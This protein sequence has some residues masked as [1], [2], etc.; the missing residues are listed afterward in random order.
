MKK[1]VLPFLLITLAA[2]LSFATTHTITNSGFTFTPT[3]LTINVGD[4]VNFVLDSIHQPR[5]VS[6]AT[7]NANG[8]TSNGGFNL[9]LGGGTVVIT[10]PGVHYYVCVPH[11]SGGMKGTITANTL[12]GIESGLSTIPANFNLMQN[13]PNP[14]NPGTVIRYSLPRESNVSIKVHDITGKKVADLLETKQGA[15]MHELKFDAAGLSTGI[16]FYTIKAG[17]F[18]QTR[19]MILM[20]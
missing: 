4:T 9:P 11:A 17:T 3:D 6:Q 8:T 2:N 15:G 16:Y 10:Q 14:F 19:K 20:K 18:T 5:E 1:V 7:W 13:Y 12:T